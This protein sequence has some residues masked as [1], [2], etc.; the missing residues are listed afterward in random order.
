MATENSTNNFDVRIR[1]LGKGLDGTF[2]AKVE[3]KA[4]G[5]KMRR[6][7][8]FASICEPDRNGVLEWMIAKGGLPLIAR[9]RKRE[10]IAKLES[11]LE[12]AR[13]GSGKSKSYAMVADRAGWNGDAFATKYGLHSGDGANV[14]IAPTDIWATDKSHLKSR[15]RSKV[16][17]FYKKFGRNNDLVKI[18]ACISF[19]PPLLEL[20]KNV[21]QP[22]FIL[23]G[24]P[25]RGKSS[26]LMLA[27]SVWGG[28][29]EGPLGFVSS[30]NSTNIGVE[31]RSCEHRDILFGLD[32]L[33][34]LEAKPTKRAQRLF[35]LIMCLYAGKKRGRHREAPGGW[36]NITL[37]ASN[38]GVGKIMA[39]GRMEYKDALRDR[40]IEL[41]CEYQ[42]GAFQC[43]PSDGS[44]GK[45]SQAMKRESIAIRGWAGEFFVES[46]VRCERTALLRKL[47]ASRERAREALG[48]GDRSRGVEAFAALYA[49]GCVAADVG[50]LPW[51]SDRLLG[52]VTRV[53]DEHRRLA[54]GQAAERS[55]VQILRKYI[56]RHDKRFLV[57]SRKSK[58]CPSVLKQARGV[59]SLL[60]KQEVELCF[61][62]RAFIEVF[63][64]SGQA[65]FA[66]RELKAA[67]VL[68]AG[69]TKTTLHR[70]FGGRRGRYYCVDAARLAKMS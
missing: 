43:V 51:S 50:L 52:A 8:P 49:A 47:E 34:A 9:A 10:F 4:Y 1:R 66:A 20:W 68:K 17:R 44:A 39:E 23:L 61:S 53:Y 58:V 31:E 35:D 37:A 6:V 36:R 40:V 29:L 45:F 24:P 70:T 56:K 13:S 22:W 54:E 15:S 32:D 59:K 11:E 64:D 16:K 65:A 46:L 38:D 60:N 25:G 67:K 48:L 21:E 14:L 62:R 42:H 5:E 57:V 7:F 55:S 18:C 33:Q 12:A 28:D 19:L 69:K 2:W 26:L 41:P 63:S 30:L 27:C 3:V